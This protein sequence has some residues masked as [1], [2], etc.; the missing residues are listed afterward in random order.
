MSPSAARPLNPEVTITVQNAAQELGAIGNYVWLDEDGDGDQDAGEAGIPNVKVE[1]MHAHG[2][3]IA[4]HLHRR[5]RRLP[6]HRPAGGQ[7][8]R[9]R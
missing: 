5:Q 9:S 2:T 8:R 3:V 6:L 1:L 7:L 4:N